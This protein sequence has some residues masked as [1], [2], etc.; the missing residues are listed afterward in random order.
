MY[1]PHDWVSSAQEQGNHILIL[2]IPD[3]IGPVWVAFGILIRI[4]FY[5]NITITRTVC[6]EDMKRAG[7][8]I[9][10]CLFWRNESEGVEHLPGLM[11]LFAYKT[12]S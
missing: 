6:G 3:G 1:R 5:M 4:R 8:F 9:P 10:D 12:K 7:L 2:D 11:A